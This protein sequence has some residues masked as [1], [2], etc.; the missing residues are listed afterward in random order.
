MKDTTKH[1]YTNKTDINVNNN[2]ETVLLHF[3]L[4]VAFVMINFIKRDINLHCI[5]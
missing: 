2:S 1:N 4:S 5:K 3:L